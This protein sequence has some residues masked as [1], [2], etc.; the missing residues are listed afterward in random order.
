[1]KYTLSNYHEYMD[2]NGIRIEIC[3]N[4]EIAAKL[5][6]GYVECGF[7]VVSLHQLIPQ[8]IKGIPMP[9]QVVE[10]LTDFARCYE[11]GIVFIGLDAYLAFLQNSERMDFF[12]GLKKLLDANNANAR[13][14]IS[15]RFMN[16]SVFRNPRYEE[17]LQIVNFEG[18][19]ETDIALNI[20]LVCKNW[21]GSKENAEMTSAAL[22]V[23]GDYIPSGTFVFSAE[24]AYLPNADWGYVTILKEPLTALKKLYGIESTFSEAC[25]DALLKECANAE[26]EP[27]DLLVERF[28]GT[29]NLSVEKAPLRLQELHNDPLWDCYV[30]MLKTKG[31]LDSYLCLVLAMVKNASEFMK[32][33]VTD[34]ALTLIGSA[35]A[36]EYASER[37]KVLTGKVDYEPLIARF[38]ATTEDDDRALDYLNCGTDTEIKGLIRHAKKLEHTYGLPEL[39]DRI[40]PVLNQYLSPYF[41]YGYSELT[42]YFHKLRCYRMSDSIDKSFVK[43]AFGAVIPKIIKK[44]DDIIAGFDDGNTALLVVDG[45]GA[46]YYPLLLNMAQLN[47]LK[48]ESRQIVS[49]RL[50][51]STDYN[52]IKWPS[53]RKLQGV[54]RVDNISHEGY[55]AHEKCGFEENLAAIFISFRK[56]IL[57]RII[58]GLGSY[59]RVIVT[60][61]HGA[62]YLA[63]NAHQDNL[64]KT[65]SWSHGAVADWRYAILNHEITTPDGM[66]TVY[67]SEMQQW[68]YVVKGYNRLPKNGGKLYALHGGATL[69][70]ILVPFVV[71]TNDAVPNNGKTDT[72]EFIEDDAFDIL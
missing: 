35:K 1:M 51:S 66:V 50:P 20:T 19:T 28:G 43:C 24:E 11:R 63:V 44:R 31:R 38:V 58:N 61:D 48:V 55:S 14:L 64:D 72:G 67:S 70:E 62:S 21:A 12:I 23:M 4:K 45:M 6:A 40:S 49:V 47:G 22:K 42:D 13:F 9:K 69:E 65:L 2:L 33:Y 30:W 41:D 5:V 15:D 36:A 46:E 29:N 59:K 7:V 52:K 25:A 54:H 53:E 26:Q 18:E 34:T 37:A 56:D 71:F 17:G 3:P 68:F 39:Y 27:M 16:R 10:Y 32:C 60:A 57:P 8:T